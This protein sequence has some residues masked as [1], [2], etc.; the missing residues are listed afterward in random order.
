[1]MKHAPKFLLMNTTKIIQM[2]GMTKTHYSQVK[3]KAAF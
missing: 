1:M 3:I 2:A